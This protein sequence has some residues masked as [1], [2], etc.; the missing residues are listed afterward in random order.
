VAE[1]FFVSLGPPD[2]NPNNF[3][4]VEILWVE[5]KWREV[6]KIVAEF[7][8]IAA[9]SFCITSVRLRTLSGVFK[10]VSAE[11]GTSGRPWPGKCPDLIRKG[12]TSPLLDRHRC[13]TSQT[14]E[15]LLGEGA[16]LTASA[17]PDDTC[18]AWSRRHNEEANPKE[19][20]F[21]KDSAFAPSEARRCQAH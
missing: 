14:S 9:L 16:T 3:D 5:Y 19:S 12:N 17:L 10:M 11:F 4:V 2:L 20:L 18:A 15:I 8:L 7:R 21:E 13:N 6:G 1:G